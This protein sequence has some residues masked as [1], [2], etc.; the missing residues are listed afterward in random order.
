MDDRTTTQ[1]TEE[2]RGEPGLPQQESLEIIPESDPSNVKWPLGVFSGES[3]EPPPEGV[4][5]SVEQYRMKSTPRGL[6]V[7]INNKVFSGKMKKREGTDLDADGLVRLF[8]WLS[9]DVR[10][11]TDL[12]GKQM[13]AVLKDVARLD[14]T[15]VDSLVV[16][17]LTHGVENELYGSDEELIPVSEVFKPFNGY[18]CPSLVSKPKIFIIQACRGGVFDYGVEQTDGDIEG[19]DTPLEP[20]LDFLKQGAEEMHEKQPK[21]WKEEHDGLAQILPA[22]ADVVAVYATVPGYV[23]WRNSA[24]GSWFIKA[25]VDVMFEHAAKSSLTDILTMVNNRVALKFQSRDGNKQIPS[26]TLQLRKLLFFNPPNPRK[27]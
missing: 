23:S 18:N 22:E 5:D 9:Y 14:H 1:P 3:S 4:D 26:A 21:E 10:L 7:I 17:I 13:M 25:F 11:F 16:C 2:T 20:S 8:R 6:A 27:R 12:K 24:F 19:Q 15:S